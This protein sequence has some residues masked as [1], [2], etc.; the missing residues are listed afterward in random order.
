MSP[1]IEIVIYKVKDR[2]AAKA[3][4]EEARAGDIHVSGLQ[5]MAGSC[6]GG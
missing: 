6:I 4:W 2:K 5:V 1:C 3:L